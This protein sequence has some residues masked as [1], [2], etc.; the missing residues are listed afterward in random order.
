MTTFLGIQILGALFGIFM[1][2]FSFVYFKRREFSLGVLIFW[3]V[4]WLAL[5][6][7]SIFPHS[8][9]FFLQELGLIR[10]MDLFM[11]SGFIIAFGLLFYNYVIVQRLRKKME[12]IVREEALKKC[13]A[14]SVK[15][16]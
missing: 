4:L 11:V 12:K 16:R 8:T 6:F 3:E 1:A 5:I 15:L 14:K 10:A 13:K 9:N 7:I 2:Y